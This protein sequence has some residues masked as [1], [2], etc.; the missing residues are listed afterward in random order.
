M[1]FLVIPILSLC[2]Y[3]Y[4]KTRS[5]V[6]FFTLLFSLLVTWFW[7]F[8]FAYRWDAVQHVV[9]S[10]YYLTHSY[11]G[12]TEERH[13]FLYL[14][15]GGFYRLF[16]ES[17]TLTHLINMS[18]GIC[19]IFGIYAISRELY[20]DFTAF[21]AL[22]VSLT[23]PAFFLVNKW[24]YL[25]MPF[26]SF[27]IITFFFLFKYL[28]TGSDRF[29][30]SSLIFAFISYGTK[31]PGLVL[32]PAILA[33]LFI[34]HRVDRKALISIGF[35]LLISV[36]YYF[37]VM[38]YS[39]IMAEF[40]VITP[41]TFGGDTV[42][43]WAGFLRHEIAQ[44]IY[45]G[46]FFLSVF[47][48]LKTEKKSEMF[49][50]ALLLIQILLLII[51]E[52]YP[53]KLIFSFPLFPWG[54]YVP[55]YILLGLSVMCLLVSISL[56]Q[57]EISIDKRGVAMLIW[58]ASLTAFFI[59]NGRVIDYGLKPLLDVSVLDF[60]YL[61]PAMPA[62]IILFSSGISKIVGSKVYSEK[63]K[64]I[65]LLVLALTLI[66]NFIIATNSTFYYANSGNLRAE[67]YKEL[68][69]QSP[70]V[71]YTHWPF[72]YGSGYDIGKFAW[73]KDNITVKDIHSN[74]FNSTE[75]RTFLLFDTYCYTPDRLVDF[76]S[77]K[78][79]AK[80]YLLSPLSTATTEETVNSVYILKPE[81]GS[82][83]LRDGF[84]TVEYWDNKPTRWMGNSSTLY[85]YSDKNMNTTLSMKAESFYCQR[86][87]EVYVN[88][89]VNP[90]STNMI[91][92]SFVTVE[93]AV[94]LEKGM[95]LI[96][97]A[98]VEGSNKPCDLAD[99]NPED[100]RDLSVAIQDIRLN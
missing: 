21:I 90:V 69:E 11:F 99:S 75:D 77:K 53:S 64:H 91:P 34:Y 13:S 37:K 83:V 42:A 54:N 4:Y 65:V 35:M 100:T 9:R 62:L 57:T 82:I 81:R 92:T 27:V 41:L 85:I 93:S 8:D 80:T 73:V 33:C 19:G 60:R 44:Y 40:S 50:Y 98:T 56:R 87:L 47:A 97:L 29:F 12:S 3:R 20:D 96:K 74:Y 5:K 59:I 71:V 22:L 32:F 23:F 79:E 45:T 72:Y 25:D 15:W 36:L 94:N 86:T 24:A 84:Y 52:N 39:A 89:N 51:S 6:I 78:I 61:M 95:N 68:Q 76:N 63:S 88:G 49:L 28:N 30:Y 55:Y 1:K 10:K 46:I 26:T 43:I 38:Y 70:E 7:G 66:F 17:E 67:G 2:I 58:A 31:D 14:I 48:F 16:G 18:L